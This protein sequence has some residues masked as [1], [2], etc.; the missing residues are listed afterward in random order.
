MRKLATC[1]FRWMV[2]KTLRCGAHYKSICIAMVTASTSEAATAQPAKNELKFRS[3]SVCQSI[4]CRVLK[5]EA[6]KGN[7]GFKSKG[8]LICVKQWHAVYAARLA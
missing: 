6:W 3:A 8:W 2:K 1:K 5:G 4:C 7:G